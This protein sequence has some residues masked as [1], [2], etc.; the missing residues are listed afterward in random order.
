[1]ASIYS[2]ANLVD[3][4]RRRIM[5]VLG[6]AMLG[7]VCT[8]LYALS[9]QHL[10]A[11][12]EVLQMQNAT[13]AADLAPSTVAGSS[14]RRLQL[15][16]QQ[17]MSRG[18]VL[19]TIADLGLFTD[20]PAMTESEQV[21]ALRMSVHIEGV[22]A[23]R[24]GYSDDGTVSLLRIT[25]QWPSAKGAQA[26]AHE[27]AQRTIALS[28]A[29]R[30]EQARETLA[31]FEVQ[32]TALREDIAGLE[33]EISGFL[34]ENDLSRPGEAEATRREI[35]TLNE[36]MLSID[37]QMIALQGR[38][39]GE[40]ASRVEKRQREEDLKVIA[41]LNEERA[42]L[43]GKIDTLQASLQST[44]E[45]ELQLAKFDHR[46]DD[47][48]TQLQGVT[49]HRKEADVSYRLEEQRQS[50]R[51][52]ILEPAPLPDYP[53]TRARKQIV[54]LGA[55]ASLILGLAAAFLLDWRHPVLRSAAHMEYYTGLRPVVSIPEAQPQPP[56]KPRRLMR[57]AKNLNHRFSRNA[58]DV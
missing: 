57:F 13:I 53:F 19:E 6:V 23:A 16:E 36:A 7:T 20:R 26:I 28:I 25:A 37:R 17:V 5:I 2:I 51:L 8:I 55:F 9:H 41:G 18:A 11:S 32:E 54:V 38:M 34:A 15:I 39:T 43:Q 14:A 22:A 48:R 12:T 33:A 31:F 42:L 52:T 50:E 21:A 44:P 24:E 30:L 35:E 27:F 49:T 46:M 58:R 3:M 56:R 29:T 4:V 45:I 40:G 47:L 10:Y 1:M